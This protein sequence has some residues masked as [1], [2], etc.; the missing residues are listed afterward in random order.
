MSSC[1][2]NG[3]SQ[4][5]SSPVRAFGL[6]VRIAARAA[7]RDRDRLRQQVLERLGWTVHRIWSTDWFN[8]PEAETAKV[9]AAYEKALE[10]PRPVV[11]YV[12]QADQAHPEPV[13]VGSLVERPRM[14]LRQGTRPSFRPGLPI[15]EYPPSTLVQLVR[16][17]QS[18]GRL[19]TESEL[20]DEMIS[21]LEFK[22]R[23][24]RIVQ[25]LEDAIRQAQKKKS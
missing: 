5:I 18:D 10:N 8:D 19:R 20:V 24:S 9:M 4:G 13:E 16:F 2:Q 25:A 15:K 12:E 22:R 21:E 23:G 1:I 6:L 7:A 17:I 3:R 11:D 14:Y